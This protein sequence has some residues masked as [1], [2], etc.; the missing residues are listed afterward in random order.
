MGDTFGLSARSEMEHGRMAVCQVDFDLETLYPL[1]AQGQ[2]APFDAD[3]C[4]VL[5]GRA[6]GA[7]VTRVKRINRATACLL[8]LCDG[9]R[10]VE[11]VLQEVSRRLAVQPDA[12]PHFTA[13]ARALMPLDLAELQRKGC[14]A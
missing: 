12:V 2:A 3:P 11:Q 9:S 6:R 4:L 7:T 5:I 8:D 10:P 13:E 1:L 14:S